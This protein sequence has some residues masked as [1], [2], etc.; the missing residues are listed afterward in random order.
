MIFVLAVAVAAAAPCPN[1]VTPEALV[2]RALD[3]QKR[4]DN[5]AAA[6]GFEEAARASSDKDPKAALNHFSRLSEGADSRTDRA[7]A[8]YWL[9]RSYAAIGDTGQAKDAWRVAAQ[10]S[11]GRGVR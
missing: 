4:G 7:R 10:D 9:G 3:A 11:S 1:V 8:D 6:Q 5:Q 2:C